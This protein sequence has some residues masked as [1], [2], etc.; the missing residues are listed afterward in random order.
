MS[1][2]KL[3][4]HLADAIIHPDEAEFDKVKEIYIK[5]FG[6]FAFNDL[7]KKADKYIKNLF[8]EVEEEK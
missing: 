3:V 5:R 1:D 8:Q 4:H 7:K 2:E 6:Q